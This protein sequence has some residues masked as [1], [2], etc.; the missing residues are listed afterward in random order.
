[1][2]IFRKK[3]KKAASNTSFSEKLR[4][5]SETDRLNNLGVVEFRSGN[6]QGAIDYYKKALDIMPENDDSLINIAM[7]LNKIGQFDE[8]ISFCKKAIE[9]DPN[10]AEGYRTIGDSYYSQSRWNEV[11][12]W[13]RE[14]AKRGDQ[15]TRNWLLNNG[16]SLTD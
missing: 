5:A 6:I 10:R 12:K 3:Q 14:S 13:Y 11:V 8:A 15:S 16:Y 4:I 7:C 1:M 2:G 9:I